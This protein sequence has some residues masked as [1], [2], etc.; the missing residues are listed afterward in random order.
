MENTSGF[1]F[2]LNLQADITFPMGIII[3]QFP[4]D[5][6]PITAEPI[7]I[8]ESA[9]GLNGDLIVWQKAEP[10]KLSFSVIPGG[11]DDDNLAILADNN[12]VAKGKFPVQDSITIVKIFPNGNTETY[13]NGI[14]MSAPVGTGIASTGRLKTKT[15]SFAFEQKI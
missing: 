3:S 7:N 5:A 4:D 12:R 9:M 15:Y 14:L 13:A 6:D 11:D 8:A 10:I 2:L 1:G